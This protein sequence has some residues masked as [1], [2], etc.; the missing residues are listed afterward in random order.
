MGLPAYRAIR[1]KF[2]DAELIL[3]CNEW[4]EQLLE[5]QGI[6]DKFIVSRIP[7]AVYDYSFKNL[8]DVYLQARKLKKN[9]L[10]L[11]IDFRGDMRNIFLLYLTKAKR[12]I[13]Y[14]F[15]GGSYWLTDIVYP[16]ANSHLIERNLNVTKY[17]GAENANNIPQIE[18]F[19]AELQSTKKYFDS[20]G[21]KDIV[22]IHPGASYPGKL[23]FPERFVQVINH[24]YKK[25]YS[26]VLIAGPN[27]KGIIESIQAM[28]ERPVKTVSVTLK[29]IAAYLSCGKLFIGLDSGI[30]HIAAAVGID[31]ITL[32]GP[33]PPAIASPRG[34]GEIVKIMKGDFDCRPCHKRGCNRDNACMKAI[35]TEDVIKAIEEITKVE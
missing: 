29:E 3:W 14:D 20:R 5:N 34:K 4:G 11:A 18:I 35:Q 17:I 1:G 27:D 30:G 16:P 7:W 24:L 10:D 33:Q 2:P 19:Q 9:N 31:V 21:L 8:K 12:R 26:P 6:F 13:S 23:W 25:N 15:T 28:L 32:F 22:F